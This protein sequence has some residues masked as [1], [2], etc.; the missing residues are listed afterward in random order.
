MTSRQLIKSYLK[1]LPKCK[2]SAGKAAG[3][4]HPH[5]LLAC[6]NQIFPPPMPPPLGGALGTEMKKLSFSIGPPR[7]GPWAPPM[8]DPMA[9][10]GGPN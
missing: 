7:G 9:P 5:I 2:K 4:S 10:P 3:G 6:Q 1:K 8:G